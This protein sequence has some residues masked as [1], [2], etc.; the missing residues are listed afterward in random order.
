MRIW[1]EYFTENVRTVFAIFLNLQNPF[2]IYPHVFKLVRLY[3]VHPPGLL[4][5]LWQVA[6][7][8]MDQRTWSKMVVIQKGDDLLDHLQAAAVPQAYGG[9][10]RDDSGGQILMD[11]KFG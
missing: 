8:I 5:I 2:I 1:S 4:S 10:R 9:Q 11:G 3:L 7:H 6:K